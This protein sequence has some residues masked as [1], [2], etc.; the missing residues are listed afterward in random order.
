MTRAR[1]N[2]DLGDSYGT[3]GAGVTGGSG[4]DATS[5]TRNYN[6][7]LSRPST[8]EID[9][10][11]GYLT[12]FD[13]SNKYVILGTG[14]AS[15]ACDLRLD[16]DNDSAGSGSNGLLGLDTGSFA[17]S[18]FYHLYVIHNG[19]ATSCVA[20]LAHNWIST[21][22]DGSAGDTK[23]V[24]KTNISGYTYGKYIGAVYVESGGTF[25]DFNQKDN[26]CVTTSKQVFSENSCDATHGCNISLAEIIPPTSY[27]MWLD[28]STWTV[29]GSGAHIVQKTISNIY[30]YSGKSANGKI[31]IGFQKNEDDIG[32]MYDYY[33]VCVDLAPSDNT[34]IWV[35]T[36][37]AYYFTGVL[38][39]F[40]YTNPNI[41]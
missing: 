29:D 2:A 33:N 5:V 19:S 41:V 8:T 11:A 14:V 6:V 28:T 38:K 12:L 37:A 16:Q 24:D 34:Q 20:S 21:T 15:S 30:I 27:R 18:T 40:E 26:V 23:G 13:S 31:T 36:D 1:D 10:D 39:R 17:N 7:I 4:L 32:Y 22:N 9:I 35:R 3:L 25:E